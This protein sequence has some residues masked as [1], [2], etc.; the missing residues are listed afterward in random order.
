MPSRRLELA[1]SLCNSAVPWNELKGAFYDCLVSS[2]LLPPWT[3]VSN[4]VYPNVLFSCI[5]HRL[6]NLE[7]GSLCFSCP[8]PG[9]TNEIHF[10]KENWKLI[11]WLIVRFLLLSRK[12]LEVLA[13]D[14]TRNE[15]LI[16]LFFFNLLFLRAWSCKEN[17]VRWKKIFFPV[18]LP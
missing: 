17:S 6:F 9:F 12:A 2:K 7:R 3:A 18:H 1:Q 10:V 13:S 14:K 5:G 8:T 11:G 16:F 4:C 15:P